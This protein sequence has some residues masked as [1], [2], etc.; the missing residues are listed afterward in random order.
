[1]I[2]IYFASNASFPVR[3][4]FRSRSST[5]A[6]PYVDFNPILYSTHLDVRLEHS[7]IVSSIFDKRW[8]QN[9]LVDQ[10]IVS[11]PFQDL[12]YGKRRAMQFLKTPKDIFFEYFKML[13]IVQPSCIPQ[14]LVSPANV[15]IP[16]LNSF[17]T[18]VKRNF[19]FLPPI[20]YMYCELS[21]IIGYPKS[22][23]R[24][25]D[26]DPNLWLSEDVNDAHNSDWY[27]KRM[28]S[29]LIS[30]NPKPYVSYKE[31]VLSRWLWVSDGSSSLSKLKLHNELIKSKFGVAVSLTDSELIKI[32][33]ERPGY[34]KIDL[35]IF[36]KP[37]EKGIKK[38]LITSVTMSGY[39]K[40]AYIRYLIGQLG[41][42]STFMKDTL[43]L[44]D[45][46][47]VIDLLRQNRTAIP[48]DESKFDYHVSS[49]AY[50]GFLKAIN[51]IFPNNEG[52]KI[53]TEWVN[54]Q[55]MW[56]YGDKKGHWKKGQ[57]SGLALT[58][59]VNSLINYCKQ[60][61]IMS[62]I[63][64]A[65]GDDV[66]IFNDDLTLEQISDFYSTFGCIVNPLKN[67]SS[68]NYA[69]YL[70]FLF[71][72]FGKTGYPARIYSSLMFAHS[73]P[74]TCVST[75]LFETA[76]LFKELY[77]RSLLKIDERLVAADLSRSVANVLKS[78]S[79]AKAMYWLHIP[80]ALSGFGLVPIRG[81]QF[82]LKSKTVQRRFYS[83][84]ILQ[85]PPVIDKL[86]ISF[87]IVP[88]KIKP[89]VQMRFGHLAP[90]PPISSLAQWEQRINMSEP[91]ITKL[92]Y[93]YG[94]AT[95]PLISVPFVSESRMAMLAQYYGFYAWPNVS[96]DSSS[97]LSR[98]IKGGLLLCELVL[99]MMENEKI[100][101]YL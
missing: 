35:P 83:D 25:L 97:R 76:S 71:S 40:A 64:Y 2:P 28:I 84:S 69:E 12:W 46:I 41:N 30:S 60:M 43:N 101:F 54:S 6:G 88:F 85:L 72:K 5:K 94:L 1:M 63:H 68:T 96:G 19:S 59:L 37:D 27:S 21:S 20:A 11:K 33:Y 66:L 22:A 8:A 18:F 79:T 36:I 89:D 39:L 70:H 75:K 67:F 100:S 73:L 48:I 99:N 51:H 4:S 38:R 90:L 91:D 65:L 93:E 49:S 32:A 47:K 98:F 16:F 55:P 53:F 29:L 62:P 45:D 82:V 78:F 52:V 7:K 17:T 74:K 13:K 81:S 10:D 77:D 23:D 15:V 92:Q 31:F 57:P 9:Q 87:Q 44:D 58:S 61:S 80:R 95:I 24:T 3:V 14:L 26:D 42:V 34:D 56:A 50:Q 86:D